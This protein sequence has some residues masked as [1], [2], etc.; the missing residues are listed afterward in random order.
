LAKSPWFVV[1]FYDDLDQALAD[2][3]GDEILAVFRRVLDIRPCVAWVHV[4]TECCVEN[5]SRKPVKLLKVATV[6]CGEQS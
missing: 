6:D 5:L 1:V 4:R 2:T 3:G